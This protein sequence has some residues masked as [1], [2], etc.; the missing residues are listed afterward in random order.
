MIRQ[1]ELMKRT[2]GGKKRRKRRET[3]EENNSYLDFSSYFSLS[4]ILGTKWKKEGNA[5]FSLSLSFFPQVPN[6]TKKS[7]HYTSRNWPQLF[8]KAL[9]T[10]L[11]V[12][13]SIPR[14]HLVR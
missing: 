4:T 6:K 2:W 8:V 1:V 9:K 5:L 7:I 10:M 13:I 14:C 11:V 12:I 3:D